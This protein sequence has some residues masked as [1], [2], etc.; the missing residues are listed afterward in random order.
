V[1]K[2]QADRQ[3]HKAAQQVNPGSCKKFLTLSQFIFVPPS[4]LPGVPF[5]QPASVY[6]AS[7]PFSYLSYH[8]SLPVSSRSDKG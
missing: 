1:N 2:K 4:F 7:V 8:N 3:C 5:D 6:T